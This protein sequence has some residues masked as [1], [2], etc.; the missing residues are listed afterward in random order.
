MERGEY[1]ALK[2]LAEMLMQR[3]GETTSSPVAAAM[4]LAYCTPTRLRRIRDGLGD[5]L[6]KK[7]YSS[8]P[9]PVYVT[10]LTDKYSGLPDGCCPKVRPLQVCPLPLR[11]RRSPLERQDSEVGD[12]RHCGSRKGVRVHL[13]LQDHE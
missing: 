11:R 10:T 7:K 2:A 9:S 12:H 1:R 8:V 5:T 6:A 3:I 13:I 4:S